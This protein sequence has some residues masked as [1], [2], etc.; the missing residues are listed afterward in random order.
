MHD[1]PAGVQILLGDSHVRITFPDGRTTE[2]SG[3][4][5]ASVYRPPLS[6]SVENLGEGYSGIVVDLKAAPAALAASA[7]K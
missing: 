7:K 1:H 4:A 6:H 5:G 2:A 3:K